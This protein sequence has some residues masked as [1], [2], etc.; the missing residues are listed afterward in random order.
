[1]EGRLP[2]RHSSL[3]SHVTSNS[4]LELPSGHSDWGLATYSHDRGPDLETRSFSFRGDQ[5]HSVAYNRGH[6]PDRDQGVSARS[7]NHF[8]PC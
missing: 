7:L 4:V 1:M 5:V 3:D 8:I 6:P 2:S